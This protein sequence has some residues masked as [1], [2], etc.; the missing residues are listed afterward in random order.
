MKLVPHPRHP[1]LSV[2]AVDASVWRDAGR[3]HF[4][5]IVD[6]AVELVVPNR[7]AT[8][9]ADELWRTTC[10]EAFV[11]GV[12][13]SYCELN[14]SPSRQWAAYAFDAPRQGMRNQAA[15]VEVWLEGGKD[16]IA[17]EAAV[18]AEL[19]S[20]IPLGLT[21]VIDERGGRKSYWALAHNAE[22]PDFH[23]PSCFLARLPE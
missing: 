14:F 15:E 8:G 7:A 22:Q 3:W 21:A 2:T 18:E 20:E 17:V 6:G 16:W 10:F 5:F 1:P 4:R 9:R 13:T 12:G 11:G 23:D 19:I